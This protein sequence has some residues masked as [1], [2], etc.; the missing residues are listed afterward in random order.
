MPKRL[1]A[2]TPAEVDGSPLVYNARDYNRHHKEI[3]AIECFLLGP[4]GEGGMLSTL[5]E[6]EAV[7]NQVK[8][9][10][11]LVT[12]GGTVTSGGAIQL[13]ANVVYTTLKGPLSAAATSITV[14][15]ATGFPSSGYITKFNALATSNFCT[16]GA[17]VGPGGRCVAGTGF[18]FPDY[19]AMVGGSGA[20]TMPE[21]IR[22][23]D[24]QND[25][26]LD[27]TRAVDGSTAQDVAASDGALVVSGKASLMLS[28]NAWARTWTKP[29]QFYLSC[30]A[31]LNVYG[32]VLED[33]SPGG[34]KAP[35]STVVEIGY[36]LVIVGWYDALFNTSSLACQV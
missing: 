20:M 27:C 30:D 22:Y 34:S 1:K 26:F 7:V 10:G 33:G 13:P 24:V 36:S 3:R 15:D 6:A 17:G 25:V 31:L 23:E 19:P 8:R 12:L 32:A 16:G 14:G 28:H 5:A 2:E 29:S 11:A 18:Q 4:G 35:I 9:G 21:V